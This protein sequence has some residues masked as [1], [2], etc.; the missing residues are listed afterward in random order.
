VKVARPELGD[1]P[2]FRERFR[3]EIDSARAVGGF[4]TAAVV[5]ADADAPRPWLAT[6]YVPG[7]TLRDAVGAHGPLPGAALRRLVAGLAEALSAIHGA[8][9]PTGQLEEHGRGEEADL[10]EQDEDAVGGCQLG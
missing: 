8:G 7:P 1:D 4:W 6:E 9:F 3:Q 2:A 5:D 10:D